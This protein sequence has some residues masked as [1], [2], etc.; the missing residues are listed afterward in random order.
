VVT[1]LV[2]LKN[3]KGLGFTVLISGSENLR[4]V[5]IQEVRMQ[6]PMPTT[7]NKIIVPIVVEQPNNIE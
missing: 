1:L 2:T 3:P 6:V 5:D 4:N 7:S